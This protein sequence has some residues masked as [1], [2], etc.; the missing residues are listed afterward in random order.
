MAKALQVVWPSINAKNL[1]KR[2]AVGSAVRAGSRLSLAPLRADVF[3]RQLRSK[4]LHAATFVTIR[5]ASP[6]AMIRAPLE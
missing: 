5:R 1:G 2:I 4:S 6:G 3:P